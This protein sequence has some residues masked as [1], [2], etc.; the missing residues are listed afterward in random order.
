[1]ADYRRPPGGPGRPVPVAG[2]GAGAG[3]A[4]L[5]LDRFWSLPFRRT[6]SYERLRKDRDS[7][8]DDAA[9]WRLGGGGD[10]AAAAA[11]GG[12][13]ANDGWASTTTDLEDDADA[14]LLDD[15]RSGSGAA[16]RPSRGAARGHG[17]ASWLRRC[18]AA[19][20]QGWR[21]CTD[22]LAGQPPRG[23]RGQRR[24]QMPSKP[25][26]TLRLPRTPH[27]HRGTRGGQQGAC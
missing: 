14:V 16:A 4:G 17:R 15:F 20:A 11:L 12:G 10:A 19:A 25:A 5:G 22:W 27:R 6:T 21:R 2:A 23:G 24:R 8:D 1:M 18:S 9:A 13:A 3:G 7:D 26:R